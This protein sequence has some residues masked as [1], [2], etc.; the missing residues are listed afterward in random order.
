MDV[1]AFMVAR[2]VSIGSRLPVPLARHPERSEGSRS[3]ASE[4]LRFTQD[5]NTVLECLE[6][7]MRV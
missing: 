2:G 4:I 5:D 1:W 6:R 7:L 3:P